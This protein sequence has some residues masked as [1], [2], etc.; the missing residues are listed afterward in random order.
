[1]KGSAPGW[2]EIGRAVG[3]S[4]VGVSYWQDNDEAP[5]DYKVHEP[6]AAFF[7]ADAAWLIHGKGKPPNSDLW[8]VWLRYRRAQPKNRAAAAFK[9]ITR[10]DVAADKKRPRKQASG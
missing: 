9:E 8:A 1:M 3:R 6:L 5:S 4:G 2:A 10:A 7:G